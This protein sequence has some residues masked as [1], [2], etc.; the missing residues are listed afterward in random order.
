MQ[1]WRRKFQAEY[2][3]MDVKPK[4]IKKHLESSNR[5]AAKRAIRKEVEQG[6]NKKPK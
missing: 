4:A 2:M 5:L 6:A 1:D 3:S